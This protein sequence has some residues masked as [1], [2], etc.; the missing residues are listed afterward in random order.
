MVNAR[1]WTRRA[2]AVTRNIKRA[3][4]EFEKVSNEY[5]ETRNAAFSNDAL[6]EKIDMTYHALVNAKGKL[7]A[8]QA[9]GKPKTRT[10]R[11]K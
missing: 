10:N 4:R 6:K 11:R 8:M 2:A 1:E 5:E 9:G 7:G 3:A